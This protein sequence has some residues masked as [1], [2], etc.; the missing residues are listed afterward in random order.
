MSFTS[1]ECSPLQGRCGVLP[2]LIPCL[3]SACFNP[4]CQAKD[5]LGGFCTSLV[6][7]CRRQDWRPVWRERSMIVPTLRV[8]TQP[9]TL[10][11]HPP[12][13]T[14]RQPPGD[15]ER[16]RLGSHH[17]SSRVATG[18]DGRQPSTDRNSKNASL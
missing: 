13:T 18:L 16:R 15:A 17:R 10:R 7:F 4:S 8:G 9:S 5:G 1:L 2:V 11:V 12:A 3:C 14:R 6:I